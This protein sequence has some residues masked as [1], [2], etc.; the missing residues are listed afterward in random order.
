MNDV[1]LR[2]LTQDPKGLSAEGTIKINPLLID[3]VYAEATQKSPATAVTVRPAP[4][5]AGKSAPLALKPSELLKFV[6][7]ITFRVDQGTVYLDFKLGA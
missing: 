5:D 7:T 4:A 1:L 3:R 6:K 2:L